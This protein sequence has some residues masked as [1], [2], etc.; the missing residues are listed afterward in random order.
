M[1]LYEYQRSTSLIDLGLN[2]TDSIYLNFFS[3]I[4]TQPVKA[5]FHVEPSWNGGTKASSNRS[6]HLTKMAAILIYGKKRLKI[7]F[8][9]TLRWLST[10]KFVQMML[11]G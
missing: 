3:S 10:T 11:L 6:G 9:G 4:T 8:S 2:I 1:N 7:F 5:K